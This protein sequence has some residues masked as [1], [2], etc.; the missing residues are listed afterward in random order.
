MIH[1]F[2]RGIGL[3]LLLNSSPLYA[4]CG[5]FV[6]QADAK[7]FNEASQVVIVRDGD[8]TVLT[9]AND[10]SGNSKEFAMVV[11]VPTVLKKEQINVGEQ[12]YID[13]IDQFTAPRL[14][15][16]FDPNPCTPQMEIYQSSSMGSAGGRAMPKAAMRKGKKVQ[17]LAK[18]AIGEYDILILSAQESDALI[19]WLKQNKY[20]MPWSAR[21]V[22]K[23]YIK[24][25]MKFFVAKVNLERQ[26]KSGRV[27]L[28]PLQMAFESKRFML[29]IRLGM[30][31]AKD[32]QDLFIYAITRKGR[33][34]VTNYRNT[35]IPT[36]NEIPVYVKKEFPEFYKSMFATA[37]KQ[38]K[39]RSVMTEYAWDLSWCDPC[40]GTP[41]NS[42][43]LRKLGVFWE[44][45]PNRNNRRFIPRKGNNG[46]FITRLHVRYNQ[47]NFPEDLMLQVTSDR[48]NFQGRY[49]LRHPFSK[50]KEAQCSEYK[51][52]LE[53]TKKAQEV[54]AQNLAVLT[55]WNI[56]DIRK[57][58]DWVDPSGVSKNNSGSWYEGLWDK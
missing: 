22:L 14:A 15:E 33:V 12:K 47:K 49:V 5:F 35:R 43:E 41:P 34:E 23:S 54:R 25:G 56:S 55:G 1:L 26:E 48:K 52:Y 53:K 57:K 6:A 4:F 37:V 19:N 3:L 20:K 21:K 50:S 31:N 11:P 2:I 51:P 28:R 9:M 29:P 8:R 16:Y 39:M 32:H 13:K 42:Q 40:S 44:N 27:N 24:M 7:L 45:K 36:G 30:L 10:F 46:N 58:V 38:N 17:V 18:Y